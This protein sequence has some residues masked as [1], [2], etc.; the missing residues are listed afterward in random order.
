MNRHI[1]IL[2]FLCIAATAAL[3]GEPFVQQPLAEGFVS[4]VDPNL[5]YVAIDGGQIVID[6]SSAKVR[7]AFSQDAS[8]ANIRPGMHVATVIRPGEYLPGQPLSASIIQILQ[9]PVGTITGRIDAVDVAAGTA[10]ILGQP[11]HFTADTF[12]RGSVPDH[13][14]RSLAELKV[15]ETVTV[16]LDGNNF[17]LRAQ[18]IYVIPPAFADD[19][20]AFRTTITKIAGNTWS[21]RPVQMGNRRIASFKV[22]SGTSIDHFVRVGDFVDVFAR[23]D[24]DV[25]TAEAI[26]LAQRICPNFTPF[27][28]INYTGVITAISAASVTI[29]D[30]SGTNFTFILNEET[31]YGIN[32]PK[33]GDT[34]SIS[35]ELHEPL[36]ARRI[37]AA[38]PQP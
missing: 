38:R 4:S 5:Q 19:H 33:V 37:D 1:A 36:T 2:V 26:E 7:D 6:I 27:P 23:V 30:R 24:G 8:P 21:V 32:D 28:I 14:P 10:T 20:V 31:I 25:V 18:S 12:F 9:Q 22:T 13:D 17:M 11:I 35:A 34:V 16:F 15:G 29:A 3:A